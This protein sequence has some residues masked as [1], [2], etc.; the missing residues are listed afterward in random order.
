M[1]VLTLNTTVNSVM[2]RCLSVIESL[3]FF[4]LCWPVSASI[5]IQVHSI[6]VEV[7]CM[8]E[9]LGDPGPYIPTFYQFCGPIKQC[10]T[11]EVFCNNYSCRKTRGLELN[12][13]YSIISWIFSVI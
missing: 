2:C 3:P 9:G 12:S 6:I 8:T 4:L 13:S 10:A 7:L 11:A 1:L 5:P